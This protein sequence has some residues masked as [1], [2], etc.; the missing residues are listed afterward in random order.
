MKRSYQALFMASAMLVKGA[1]FINGLAPF[2]TL[3]AAGRDEGAESQRSFFLPNEQIA[4]RI[5]TSAVRSTAT[6]DG[7][8]DFIGDAVG[9]P[10]TTAAVRAIRIPKG[11]YTITSV[12]AVATATVAASTDA[13]TV[14]LRRS[15]VGA[16]SDVT[17]GT[18]THS[19]VSVG[20][21]FLTDMVFDNLRY[22]VQPGDLVDVVINH[23]TYATDPANLTWT[24]YVIV[25]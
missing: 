13:V 20:G 15:T 1:D 16:G 17:I 24:G 5:G 21:A 23:P 18:Y 4:I 7:S 10:S 12:R 9:A 14:E 22:A 2:P 8:V 6:I 11:K 19:T 25:E 3:E